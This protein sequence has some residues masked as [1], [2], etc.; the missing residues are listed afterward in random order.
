MYYYSFNIQEVSKVFSPKILT[1]NDKQTEIEDKQTNL[2]A[3]Q[4]GLRCL[5]SVLDLVN[6]LLPLLA[7]RLS[8]SRTL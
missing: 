5:Q 3:P 4:I 6:F 7:S 1:V 8:F 2:N